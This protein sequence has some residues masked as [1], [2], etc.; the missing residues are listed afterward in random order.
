MTPAVTHPLMTPEEQMEIEP[1]APLRVA[2]RRQLSNPDLTLE[3]PSKSTK[4]ALRSRGPLSTDEI[5]LL[6]IDYLDF[7]WEKNT[8]RAFD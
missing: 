4:Y 1:P 5:S 8:G 2:K 3:P 7:L 6:Q